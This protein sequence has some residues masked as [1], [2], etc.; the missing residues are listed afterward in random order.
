MALIQ[1]PP[2]LAPK[3]Y[4]A[5]ITYLAAVK[6]KEHID[7]LEALLRSSLAEGSFVKLS[8]GHY[9]GAEQA[10][11]HIYVKRILVKRA[12]KLSC[13]YR[14][15]TR[16]VVKNYDLPEGIALLTGMLGMVGFRVAT[17]M[18]TAAD[19]QL[20]HMA[21]GRTSLRQMPPTHSKA[22]SLDHDK[23]KQRLIA[24]TGKGY[25]TA[26]RITDEAGT[27]YKATQDKYRQ[28][29]H[30]IELL[31]SLLRELPPHDTLRVIDMGAGKGY[32]TFA[33]YDYLTTV[34]HR[35]AAV[36]G[37]EYRADLVA[38]C[39]EI[40]QREQ[41]AGLRFEQGS[42][43]EH[44]SSGAHVLIA[45]HACDTATDDAI[46]KGIQAGAELIVVAPCCHKQI[47]R[48]MEKHHT[49]GDLD[50]LLRHGIFLERQAEMV[51]DGLRA[52]LLEYSGYST[53]VFEFISDAH[54]PK[55]VMLVG[56]RNPKATLHSDAVLQ[57]INAAKERFGIGQHYL[58]KLLGL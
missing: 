24:A 56:V 21:D 47:R 26:L 41:M 57:K 3:I 10:L 25:L 32:L 31:S 12:E 9:R 23:Q 22:P 42:I 54:T 17:L 4:S 46:Y 34:L 8:L 1:K 38:L 19:I 53:R 27:V 6:S 33:L 45:L 16:D 20:E 49:A 28:I 44:D 35:Q 29:N 14:Y 2:T 15:Q 55:N 43:A 7:K 13:T 11:K 37:V 36:T 5:E 52:L 18:T 51:T 30:Y 50:F 48:E 58:E 39:N 40:A